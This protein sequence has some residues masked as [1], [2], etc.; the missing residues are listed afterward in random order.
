MITKNVPCLRRVASLE[1]T[2]AGEDVE[3]DDDWVA[4]NTGETNSHTSPE[5]SQNPSNQQEEEIGTIGAD[6][7]LNVASNT[8]ND[9]EI[10]LDEFVDNDLAENFA[11]QNT[12][13]V[14]PSSQESGD[15]I[16]KSRS[17]TLSITYD[18]YYQ[19][20]RVF[21]QGY[22]DQNGPLTEKQIFED[23]MQDYQNKTVT[24]EKHPHLSSKILQVS[25]HR[26]HY[27]YHMFIV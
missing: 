4:T 21:L 18:K 15:N 6:G 10:N 14:E 13:T 23:V 12:L 26:K 8:N 16:V 3:L 5:N 27:S 9:G 25:I 24:I 20:P 2:A 17:Y 1:I 22:D 19:T 11:D 7:A